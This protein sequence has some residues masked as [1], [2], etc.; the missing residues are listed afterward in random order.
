MA[1]R[2]AEEPSQSSSEAQAATYWREKVAAVANLVSHSHA[3]AYRDMIGNAPAKT[4]A[5]LKARDGGSQ[6]E[7]S[8]EVHDHL[9]VVAGADSS[10]IIIAKLYLRIAQELITHWRMMRGV[11]EEDGPSDE[12][13]PHLPGEGALG[14]KAFTLQTD[15]YGYI[16]NTM[17]VEQFSTVCFC[18]NLKSLEWLTAATTPLPQYTHS[19]APVSDPDADPYLRAIENLFLPSKYYAKMRVNPLHQPD[20]LSRQSAAADHVEFS[21]Q[22]DV[23]VAALLLRHVHTPTVFLL[24]FVHDQA[25]LLE[26]NRRHLHS[27]MVEGDLRAL[28][29][30]SPA[31]YTPVDNP[32]HQH[33]QAQLQ[34][35]LRACY[36]PYR[37]VTLRMIPFAYL[38]TKVRLADNGGM[39]SDLDAEYFEAFYRECIAPIGSPFIVD[40]I[41][42]TDNMSVLCEWLCW[43]HQGVLKSEVAK[44]HPELLPHATADSLPYDR[45]LL[46]SNTIE[47][48]Y[49]RIDKYLMQRAL[50]SAPT[51]LPYAQ[52][53]RVTSFAEAKRI[54]TQP[55]WCSADTLSAEAV[56]SVSID[57][58]AADTEASLAA[59]PCSCFPIV[60]KPANGAGSEFVSLCRGWADLRNAFIVGLGAE[61]VLKKEATVMCLQEY[62]GGGRKLNEPIPATASSVERYEAS[63]KELVVDTVTYDGLHYV[64]DVWYSRKVPLKIKS[65]RLRSYAVKD[66][67]KKH[68][69][70]V[71][72]RK[73]AAE[74][75]GSAAAHDVDDVAY[76]ADGNRRDLL[77][78]TFV[79]DYQNLVMPIGTATT[80]QDVPDEEIR[81]A[82]EY[83][84]GVVDALGMRNG[85]A[86]TEIMLTYPHIKDGSEPRC[87]PKLIE[88]NPR[89]QG[90]IPRCSHVLGCD[91]FI[92]IQH[93]FAFRYRLWQQRLGLP[94][95]ATPVWPPAGAL[96]QYEVN[97]SP[98]EGLEASLLN[99]SPYRCHLPYI[100]QPEQNPF[101]FPVAMSGFGATIMLPQKL[102]TLAQT[103]QGSPSMRAANPFVS[104][105][106]AIDA[107]PTGQI[108]WSRCPPRASQVYDPSR[109]TYGRAPR[110]A[111]HS[112]P[113]HLYQQNA[114]CDD[115]GAR[116]PLDA[117]QEGV[118]SPSYRLKVV[119]LSSSDNGVMNEH[120]R[121]WIR[122]FLPGF[123]RFTRGADVV[124]GPNIKKGFL[125][126][127]HKTIDIFSC[128]A[129]VLLYG[130]QDVVETSASII[131][132]MEHSSPATRPLRNAIRS[133]ARTTLSEVQLAG[134]N[135]SQFV[136]HTLEVV[137]EVIGLF[138]SSLWVSD[139]F[140]MLVTSPPALAFLLE[141]GRLLAGVHTVP[142]L[143]PAAMNSVNLPLSLL[144]LVLPI[145][146]QLIDERP[147][148]GE[149]LY[150]GLLFD[151]EECDSNLRAALP[152]LRVSLEQFAK[153]ETEIVV[154]TDSQG[155]EAKQ[156]TEELEEDD[157]R[158][159][160]NMDPSITTQRLLGA[161]SS[162]AFIS[163]ILP[164]LCARLAPS[165]TCEVEGPKTV[166]PLVPPCD[167]V[168]SLLVT[169]RMIL[170]TRSVR[171]TANE[172]ASAWNALTDLRTAAFE[173]RFSPSYVARGPLFKTLC[174]FVGSSSGAVSAVVD[175]ADSG[176]DVEDV[177]IPCFE[178]RT[179]PLSSAID[180]CLWNVLLLAQAKSG[181]IE[182]TL[183]LGDMGAEV[184]LGKAL[185]DTV[186][187]LDKCRKELYALILELR[188]LIAPYSSSVR[189]IREVNG[190]VLMGAAQ[191]QLAS[192]IRG[193]AED[194]TDALRPLKILSQYTSCETAYPQPIVELMQHTEGY[195]VE[196]DATLDFLNAMEIPSHS[197]LDA[198]VSN[199]MEKLS[200]THPV[201]EVEMDEA[202]AAAL[203]AWLQ[204][205]AAAKEACRQVCVATMS[206]LNSYT[207]TYN[208]GFRVYDYLRLGL[209]SEWR[210]PNYP[211]PLYLPTDLFA[212]LRDVSVVKALL[213][214]TFSK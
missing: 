32:T 50:Q 44:A 112:Y 61:T 1:S 134:S 117:Y 211:P 138:D 209:Y 57:D 164:S 202:I 124:K 69:A 197:I 94:T 8:D 91:Q 56:V 172:T 125:M 153:G 183:P 175:S 42:S 177:P 19:G 75:G 152:A 145:V 132:F 136:R 148:T 157:T 51:P 16:N 188:N 167:V 64:T 65:N 133:A 131:R 208:M 210:R 159:P 127:I 76:D 72:K 101:L 84:K 203:T 116:H 106:A 180:Q 30:C 37:Y 47:K 88:L 176:D 195:A 89:V 12:G 73:A 126:T 38:N 139:S 108:D 156:D 212:A 26:A 54:L 196:L 100:V 3:L 168:S 14:P 13:T 36:R 17:P 205:S 118:P 130:P 198:A 178:L 140:P 98:R 162:N 120:G 129:A 77:T 67:V 2:L 160:T 111:P 171:S 114:L 161:G 113:N 34:E 28:S 70:R 49:D 141:V 90:D 39:L 207:T 97:A 165:A 115:A 95:D 192:D 81:L 142:L 93:L 204:F 6:E 169:A 53:S 187:S 40:F 155:D 110:T 191:A 147:T 45:L 4:L 182:C 149:Q 185:V 137:Q 107:I 154:A 163:G 21:C 184:P 68:T 22:A 83:V 41:T 71:E 59:L 35:A 135:E 62:L 78:T 99:S 15:N 55:P 109:L 96:A 119:F 24:S 189:L 46:C 213:I 174:E 33:S 74:S 122:D 144:A 143:H 43:R 25:H 20:A 151:D 23:V 66:V 201:G 190:L 103:P 82:I 158:L 146:G 11:L 87:V 48:S 60:A 80:E 9:N 173:L 170:E 150:E 166:A 31:V 105:R 121:I 58:I 186:S 5:E 214:P 63:S 10:E 52:T 193:E 18:A 194:A 27:G 85:I 7:E 29:T 181:M 199:L 102:D 104:N 123:V 86:H 128:P 206:V 92:A 179:C 79:Y 200:L